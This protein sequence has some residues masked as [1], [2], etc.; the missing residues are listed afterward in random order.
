MRTKEVMRRFLDKRHIECGSRLLGFKAKGGISITT[1]ALTF[2]KGSYECE[3][4]AEDRLCKV[5]HTS[6]ATV[7]VSRD[8]G[9]NRMWSLVCNFDDMNAHVLL[10]PM[11][12]FK[13]FN[14]FLDHKDL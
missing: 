13:L 11:P 14:C 5:T 10:P 4:D 12:P 9:V 6:G 3:F 7:G 2:I 8:L 1:G